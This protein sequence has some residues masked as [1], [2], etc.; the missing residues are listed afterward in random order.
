M[1]IF[2]KLVLAILKKTAFNTHIKHHYTSNKFL[3]NTYNHKGYWY[4]GANREKETIDLFKKLIEQGDYVLEIG[5]H[6]GYFTTF[7]AHLVG[8]NGKVTVFEPSE[9]NV[10]YLSKNIDLLPTNLKKI[11]NLVQT[12]AGNFDGNLDFYIDPIT[13]QNNSFVENF[14]G[15]L[16]N[17]K[18]SIDAKVEVI[19][20]SVPVLKLDT[21]FKNKNELPNFVKIDVE[22]YEWPVIQGFE[23]NIIKSKPNFMI[24]IQA[25]EDKLIPFFLNNGYEIYNDRFESIKS[26]L[27]YENKRTPNIF[28]LFNK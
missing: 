25:D 5:G 23:I 15:F 7:Y 13:G 21:F 19:K 14:N 18:F 16:V 10:F 2:R 17:R 28:F 24:E 8:E 1:N 26:L 20:E 22:G 4:Y 11:V 27:E 12:G 9:K 3:L 6:I